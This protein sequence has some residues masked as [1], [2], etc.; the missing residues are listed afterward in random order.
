MEAEA[1]AC[2]D[3]VLVECA[4]ALTDDD[5]LHA[6]MG[7]DAVECGL[8]FGRLQRHTHTIRRTEVSSLVREWVS[9][10]AV[11]LSCLQSVVY[12]CAEVG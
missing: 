1:V 5:A 10:R 7:L 8:N 12:H 3:W 6:R 2:M 11:L 9:R 4:V